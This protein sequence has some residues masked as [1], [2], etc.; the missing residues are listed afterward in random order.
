[1]NMCEYCGIIILDGPLVRYHLECWHKSLKERTERLI[2]ARDITYF[3]GKGNPS[4]ESNTMVNWEFI[5]I[6]GQ[7]Y[8]LTPVGAAQAPAKTGI[9]SLEAGQFD[10]DLSAKVVKDWKLNVFTRK[11]D[12]TE[13]RVHSLLVGD[14][15]GTIKVAL[16]DKH[17]KTVESIQEGDVIVISGGYTKKGL[18]KDGKQFIELHAGQKS[19]VAIVPQEEQAIL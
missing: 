1:M 6:D 18:V 4:K 5:T 15:T 9:S 19:T 10:V 17:T 11:N 3:E 13:G 14:N 8:K 7:Q 16:W 12:G 2:K